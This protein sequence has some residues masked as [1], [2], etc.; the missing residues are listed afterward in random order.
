MHEPSCLA[1]LKFSIFSL[2]FLSV[3]EFCWNNGVHIIDSEPRLCLCPA[4]SWLSWLGSNVP[5]HH[6]LLPTVLFTLTQWLTLCPWLLLV[7]YEL[8]C[9]HTRKSRYL[10]RLLQPWLEQGVDWVPGKRETC[11]RRDALTCTPKSQSI[12]FPT[13]S[14]HLPMK[15]CIWGSPCAQ[16]T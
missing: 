13:A 12:P 7:H 2:N 16:G 3:G 15:I 8:G 11:S 6:P 5:T 4:S 9:Q 10:A 14:L 1:V